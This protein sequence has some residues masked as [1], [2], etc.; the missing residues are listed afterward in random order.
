M[1]PGQHDTAM[2]LTHDA[3]PGGSSRFHLRAEV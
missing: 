3:D 2:V 1:T